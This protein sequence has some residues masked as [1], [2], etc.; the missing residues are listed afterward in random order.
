M[1][2]YKF[3]VDNPFIGWLFIDKPVIDVHC[4]LNIRDSSCVLNGVLLFFPFLFDLRFI[5]IWWIHCSDPYPLNEFIKDIYFIGIDRT[6]NVYII[7]RSQVVPWY[8]VPIGFNHPLIHIIPFS[9]VRSS[10]TAQD[11]LIEVKLPFV[12]PK[13]TPIIPFTLAYV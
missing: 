2:E 7:D 5:F 10:Q 4:I 3:T 6:V 11:L 12:F 1:L 8:K 13:V 9:F